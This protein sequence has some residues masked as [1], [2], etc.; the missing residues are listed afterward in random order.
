MAARRGT[1]TK[2]KRKSGSKAKTLSSAR[3][4]KLAALS[5]DHEIVAELGKAL[6]CAVLVGVRVG[7]AMIFTDYAG[8]E[9]PSLTFAARTHAR[10]PLYRRAAGKTRSRSSS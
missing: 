9:S 7:D 5:L 2:S 4:N 10:R 3:A 6:G 8:Q 1:A